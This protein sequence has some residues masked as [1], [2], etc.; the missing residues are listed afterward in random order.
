MAAPVAGAIADAH[1]DSPAPSPAFAGSA[2][3]WAF[4]EGVESPKRLWVT[5]EMQDFT[6]AFATATAPV[7]P[8]P[9]SVAQAKRSDERP[10]WELAIG[11]E[12]QSFFD[13]GVWKEGGC[14]VPAG[15][16]ALP[17]HI[18]LDSKRDGRY[19]TR[20]V[21][22]GNHQQ[23]GV[24]FNETFAP[25]C[26]Y[27]TL[28]MIAAVAARHGLRLRQFDIKT[29][30]LPGVLEEEVYVRPL[31]GFEYLAG[32]PGRVLRLRRAMYGFRHAPRAWNMCLEAEL[33]KRSFVQS[34]ADPRLWLLYGKN[35][36][37]MYMFYMDYGLRRRALMMRQSRWLTL[38]LPCS[39]SGDSG[40]QRM[41][42]PSR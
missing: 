15:M 16:T 9:R 5:G 12:L 2:W 6:H 33:T 24:D 30:F 20:L 37:V 34:N 41:C 26:S 35:G 38:L 28:C 11:A 18:V 29:A 27:R 10:Q 31:A 23:Q 21:A 17:R 3:Y 40:S 39:Q 19:K 14:A 8:M 42:W 7:L 25:V 32:G 22:G 4:A 36:A 1:S 13:H